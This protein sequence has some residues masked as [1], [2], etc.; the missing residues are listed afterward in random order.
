MY[1]GIDEDMH[2]CVCVCVHLFSIKKSSLIFS[3]VYVVF[4]LHRE[5]IDLVLFQS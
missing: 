2:A 5:Q 4:S 1:V 3:A